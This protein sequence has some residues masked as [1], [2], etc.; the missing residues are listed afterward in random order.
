MTEQQPTPTP[1]F[2]PGWRAHPLL[3]VASGFQAASLFFAW[4]SA[5]AQDAR[6]WC[7]RKVTG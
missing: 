2:W 3:M 6:W 1:L 7:N 5:H 4:V